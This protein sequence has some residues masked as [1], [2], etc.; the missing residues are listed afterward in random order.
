MMQRPRLNRPVYVTLLAIA[1]L[2]VLS[3]F[4]LA[5][6]RAANAGATILPSAGKPLVNLKTPQNLKVTYTGSAAA[7]LQAGT[8]TPTALA[9]ADFNADGAMDVVAG[10]ST[11]NGGVMAL[12]RGNPD[13]Y[14]PSDPTLYAKALQ[15]KVPPTFLSKAPTFTLPESPDL[16]AT[17]DFNRDGHQD[18]L[19][20]AR[21]NNLYLLAGDGTGNFLA[22]QLVPLLGQ[23]TAL[24]AAPDGHVAVALNGPN[25]SQLIMLNPT[26]SGLVQS[27]SYPLP[28]QGNSVAWGSLGGRA[29]IAV[30]AGSNVVMIYNA[31]SAKPQTENVTVPF[32]VM[33]LAVGDFIW[34]QDARSEISILAGDGSVQ[35]LQHGTLNT[36]PLT[37]AQ[38]PARRAAFSAKNARAQANKPSNPTSLGVWTV[39]KQLP[40]SGTAPSAAVS[41]SA[42]SSPR[43][44]ASS[45]HDV[46]V[47]D[48]GL[49]QLSILDTSGKTES[50][51]SAVSFSAAP[52][53]ALALPQKIDAS[54]DLV[55]L[56]SAQSA[57]M[58]IPSGPDPTFD[59][60]WTSD[61]DDSGDC[62]NGSPGSGTGAGP[63]GQLSLREAVCAANNS[64]AV[65]STIDVP[66]GTFS[67][68]IS[69]WG[70]AGSFYS[71]GELQVGIANGSNITISGAG[72]TSTIIE[73]TNGIDRVIE[74]DEPVNGSEP[75]TVQYL[76]L[77]GGNCSDG[78]TTGGATGLDCFDNGGG[79]ILAGGP[80]DTLTLTNVTL[81]NNAANPTATT[82]YQ[83]NGGAL[84][85]AGPTLTI[86]GSTFSGNKASGA[87]GGIYDYDGYFNGS[88]LTGAKTITNSTF[89]N[90]TN[91]IS[92]GAIDFSVYGGTNIT[93]SGS[94]FTGNKTTESNGDGGAITAETG[95]T[96]GGSAT[97]SMSNSRIV[98]NSAPQGANGVYLVDVTPTLTNNWWGCNAGPNQSG[99]DSIL[100]DVDGTNEIYN[101]STWLVLGLSAN[102]TQIGPNGTSTLTA[103][104]THN[105][106]WRHRWIQRSQ[107]DAGHLRRHAGQQREP[108]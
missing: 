21:G 19:A 9:A 47:L 64:G 53:A 40:Y 55:V 4:P 75:L 78:N 66:A 45:T 10:Y 87:G 35:I 26:S 18:V 92:G 39:A 102:P 48:A 7:A 95:E 77:T 13:A 50:A 101:P 97:F 22:A 67:L 37:A 89:T 3:Y 86:S 108:D 41:P 42:F 65:I 84:T 70:G 25:G 49:S 12:F 103:D 80:G 51:S 72:Q 106:Q 61:E 91:I 1:G 83:E 107:R 82:T 60:T 52:I 8:A 104:L 76:T 105:K 29:D 6:I 71:S 98:G 36:A 63:D 17:G 28:A 74:A 24:A 33:G 14:A 93:I 94:T 57:P 81:T 62:G 31:L 38:I 59:V 30:G 96:N 85:Y 2:L 73:Q 68:S 69:R 34:D 32:Q 46:M 44:A 99:C 20:A 56:T 16:L 88:Y 15:G 100:Q 90:N 54:R 43:L 27:A 11:A 23:V 58:L 79:A 5:R